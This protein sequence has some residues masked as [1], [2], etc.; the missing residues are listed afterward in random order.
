MNI[1]ERHIV[2]VELVDAVGIV[3]H[4]HKVGG[5]GLHLRQT[6]DGRGGVDHAL[7]VGVL[8]HVPHTLDGGVFHQL[9]HH[10]HIRAGRRHGHGDHL[11]AEGLRDLE[12]PVVSRHRADP[13]HPVQ[14]APGLFAVQQ[15]VGIRLG[16]GVIHE[17]EAGVAYTR[18]VRGRTAWARRHRSAFSPPAR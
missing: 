18:R 17:L 6:V 7:G 14:L 4:E 12:M 16:H 15:A 5:G 13:L 3:P 2:A 11:H 1:G 8:G 10:V 9:L